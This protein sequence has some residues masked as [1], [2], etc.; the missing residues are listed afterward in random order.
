MPKQ[1]KNQP[2]RVILCFNKQSYLYDH[3]CRCP[4]TKDSF[5]YM[6][7]ASTTDMFSEIKEKSE[8]CAICS[9]LKV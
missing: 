9:Q 1:L 3:L 8:S 6:F 5:R 4:I 2:R 7:C